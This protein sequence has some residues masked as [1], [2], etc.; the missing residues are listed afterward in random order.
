MQ[1]ICPLLLATS[2]SLTDKDWLNPQSMSFNILYKSVLLIR[3]A[4]VWFSP[5]WSRCWVAESCS[6][7]SERQRAVCWK[8]WSLPQAAT[9]FLSASCRSCWLFTIYWL[10]KNYFY[11]PLFDLL[12]FIFLW[13]EL[14]FGG[15]A[16]A[17]VSLVW[18][19]PIPSLLQGNGEMGLLARRR[20]W[21]LLCFVTT[22]ALSGSP[23]PSQKAG[24]CL[25]EVGTGWWGQQTLEGGGCSGIRSLCGCAGP[26]AESE[27]QTDVGASVKDDFAATMV[28]LVLESILDEFWEKPAL[29]CALSKHVP[30]FCVWKGPSKSDFFPLQNR[31]WCCSTPVF[32][33]W[34]AAM[35]WNISMCLTLCKHKVDPSLLYW[36]FVKRLRSCMEIAAEYFGCISLVTVKAQCERLFWKNLEG[37]M[38]LCWRLRGF[39]FFFS[40]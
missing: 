31:V 24:I 11:Y 6:G 4:L 36:T 19:S 3:K 20:H 15:A 38:S 13:R 21:A 7:L 25:T 26:S 23:F 22:S 12:S 5:P 33:P 2:W 18:F 14:V 1:I 16:L 32:V 40:F 37:V 30:V 27:T 8:G 17:P 9:S 10:F 35:T 29:V 39:D 34:E 28:L